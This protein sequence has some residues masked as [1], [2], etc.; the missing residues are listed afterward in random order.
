MEPQAPEPVVEAVSDPPVQAE[1]P[2]N[3][4]R[5]WTALVALIA[6]VLAGLAFVVFRGEGPGKGAER[7]T[8]PVPDSAIVLAEGE[9]LAAAAG[10]L[11]VGGIVTLGAGRFRLADGLV[12]QRAI[13]IVGRGPDSTVVELVGT[14]GI[15]VLEGTPGVEL[16]GFRVSVA[17]GVPA[18]ITT[19]AGP[20][21]DDLRIEGPGATGEDCGAVGVG[22]LVAGSGK[23]DIARV[24]S[25]GFCVGLRI[26]DSA[27]PI[28]RG[29]TVT[30]N[31]TAIQFMKKAGGSLLDS[32]ISGNRDG[33]IVLGGQPTIDNNTIQKN[34]GFGL[35]VFRTPVPTLGK[36]NRIRANGIDVEMP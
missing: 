23:P 34:A 12:L 35:K 30:R 36:R 24:T 16:F 14:R 28:I 31:A 10:R 15:E 8:V 11:A 21:F 18:A 17:A 33:I 19:A 27:A 29:A 20:R 26:T 5:R 1:P 25:A 22:I 9:D 32:D 6:V 3:R 4:A 2:L 13:R 7:P